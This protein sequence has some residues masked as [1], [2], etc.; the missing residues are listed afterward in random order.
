[1]FTKILLAQRTEAI[2]RDFVDGVYSDGFGGG[3]Q[4]SVDLNGRYGG[5]M[6]VLA[7]TS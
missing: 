4:R 5:D 1:M 7:V 3:Q 2:V 6:V